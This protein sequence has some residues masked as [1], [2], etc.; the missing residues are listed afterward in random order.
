MP[1]TKKQFELG[2]T[3]KIENLMKLAHAHLTDHRDQAFDLSDLRFLIEHQPGIYHSSDEEDLRIALDM[4]GNL[5]VAEVRIIRD[6]KYFSY[7][8]DLNI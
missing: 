6:R 8:S 7:S 3:P 1:I 2:I 4:L 5:G